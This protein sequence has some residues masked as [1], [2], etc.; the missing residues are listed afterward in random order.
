MSIS[1]GKSAAQEGSGGG[2]ALAALAK[3]ASDETMGDPFLHGFEFAE[4]EQ[5][6]IAA[7]GAEF[8]GR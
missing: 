1:A 3:G 4:R 2:E 7:F 8:A 6:M 5:E